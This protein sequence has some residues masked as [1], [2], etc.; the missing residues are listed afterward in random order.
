MVET[1]QYL[2]KN[3]THEQVVCPVD[4][5]SCIGS[6]VTYLPLLT[7]YHAFTKYF[8]DNHYGFGTDVYI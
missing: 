3:V 2:L 7:L 5:S 8:D 6:H 1:F 4:A